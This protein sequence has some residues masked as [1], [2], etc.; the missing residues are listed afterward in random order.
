M[1]AR[2]GPL[3]TIAVLGAD[4]DRRRSV[5]AALSAAGYAVTSSDA[6]AEVI[7]W[8]AGGGAEAPVPAETSSEVVALVEPADTTATCAALAAGAAMCVP[9]DDVHALC[10]ALPAV[11]QRSRARRN[12]EA[13]AARRRDLMDQAPI[14]VFEV[15]SGRITYANDY[16]VRRSGYALEELLAMPP[17]QLFAEVDRDRLCQ[18]LA[19]RAQGAAGQ[20]TTY[21][22]VAKNGEERV[23]EIVSRHVG[24]DGD[25]VEGTVR[26]ITAEARLARLHRVVLELG[27]VILGEQSIDHILQLVLDTITEYSG[28]R[29]AVLTLYDLTVPVPLDG[30]AVTILSSGLS[31]EELAALRRQG[32]MAPRDR[33]LAFDDAFRM[34]SAYYIPHDRAPWGP[35]HGLSG[36]MEV[37][38]WN[39]DDYLFIPLRG[40]AGIIGL[41]SIDDPVDASAPTASSIEPV[42]SLAN[43]AALAVERVTKLNQ[44]RVQRDILRGLSRLGDAIAGEDDVAGLCDA[45]A[46]RVR[47]DLG[48]DYC[49]I[50]LRDRAEIVLEGWASKGT[51]ARNELPAR[52][53][54]LPLEGDG[55][56]R[57]AMKYLEPVVVDDVSSDPRYRKSRWSIRSMAAVPIL[58]RKGV[59]GAL[60]VESQRLAAFGEID[61]EVF[62]SLASQLSLALSSLGRRDTLARVYALGERIAGATEVSQVVDS[63]LDFLANQFHYEMAVI[64]LPDDADRLE[65]RGV[66]GPYSASGVGPGWSLSPERGIVSWVARNRRCAMVG[67]VKADPRYVEALPET[68]SELAVPL[69]FAGTLVGVLNVESPYPSFFDDEDRVLL[70]VVANHVATAL[71]N[72]SSQQTLR[73]QALRD[74][75]TGLFNRHHFNSII[76]PEM[77][78]S[79]RYA[80]PCTI[81]MLDVD[82]FRSVN[83][84]FGHLKGDEVLQEVARILLA[85]TRASDHVIRYGGDEFVILMPETEETEAALVAQRLREQM[86]L[87]PRR[88]GVSD[89]SMG[90]SIGIYTRRPRESASLEALLEEVDRRLYADKRARHVERADDYR[91]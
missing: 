18:A 81:M 70:E 76:A 80:R 7:V 43:F 74:P 53:T 77:S 67:D 13:A 82:G 10:T 47:D 71:S 16:L 17:S 72:L 88:A 26:D 68:R 15:E 2:R 69:L 46:R 65:V 90:L 61:L 19:A 35:E 51:F 21:R 30:E 22:L 62:A 31:P 9:C 63:A 12:R 33:R 6:S 59:R 55:L 54:R 42:A 78:R 52:G 44:L 41:I 8:F 86:S 40:S 87:V 37:D 83:N 38:G 32:P 60:D 5:D 3:A 24:E 84:R 25:R 56:T 73:A 36:T 27:S 45:A 57:W 11:V 29:R 4:P 23:V 20:P 49:G 14:G 34:G 91:H 85:Q 50:W 39:V 66:R 79:D 64:F 28:F 58:D 89:V 75:L 48:H 1:T